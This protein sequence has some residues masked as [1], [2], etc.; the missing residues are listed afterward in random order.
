MAPQ[1]SLIPGF[2][3][4][5]VRIVAAGA[6]PSGV[7]VWCVML[8]ETDQQLARGLMEQTGLRGY[9]GMVFVFPS[10]TTG[11]FWMRT[12]PIPLSIA[13]FG[14]DG[15]FVSTAEMAPCGDRA[16]CPLYGPNATYRFALETAK[17]DLTR[18]GAGP[19]ARL[20]VLNRA[21]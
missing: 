17:G 3:E 18:L 1:R 19:G 14:A 9:D 11:A 20:E 12:V 2:G 10:D 5:A 6:D 7:P 13:W 16:D 21:C 15:R 4:A 8:A